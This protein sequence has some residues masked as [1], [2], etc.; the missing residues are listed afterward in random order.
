MES[1]ISDRF[2][3]ERILHKLKET[4][5]AQSGLLGNADL[6]I[7]ISCMQAATS[8]L[9]EVKNI[10]SDLS[11]KSLRNVADNLAST[12]GHFV[13]QRYLIKCYYFMQSNG[14]TTNMLQEGSRPSGVLIFCPLYVAVTEVLTPLLVSETFAGNIASTKISQ[15]FLKDLNVLVLPDSEPE[16]F[17]MLLANIHFLWELSKKPAALVQFRNF[18][19]T[20]LILINVF[21]SYQGPFEQ[22]TT[23]VKSLAV[24]IAAEVADE[25]TSVYLLA[26]ESC[27]D[28]VVEIL[29][30]SVSAGDKYLNY[31]GVYAID[32]AKCILKLSRFEGLQ[33]ALLAKGVVELLVSMI[34]IGDPYDDAAAANALNKLVRNQNIVDVPVLFQGLASYCEK[35]ISATKTE[36]T[37][38]NDDQRIPTSK[39]KEAVESLA[40]GQVGQLAGKDKNDSIVDNKQELTTEEQQ[41]SIEGNIEDKTEK[42]SNVVSD[43]GNE[44]MISE[45][46]ITSEIDPSTVIASRKGKD[47]VT[48]LENNSWNIKEDDKRKEA[49]I[50]EVHLKEDVKEDIGTTIKIMPSHEPNYGERACDQDSQILCHETDNRETT[51]KPEEKNSPRVPST[52]ESETPCTEDRSQLHEAEPRFCQQE[53]IS[54]YMKKQLENMG[55]EEIKYVKM[56]LQLEPDISKQP[57]SEYKQSPAS[58]PFQYQTE[59][60]DPVSGQDLYHIHLSLIDLGVHNMYDQKLVGLLNEILEEAKLREDGVFDILNSVPEVYSYKMLRTGSMQR[61]LRVVPAYNDE[62]LNV[63]FIHVQPEIDYHLVLKKFVF[64]VV[65]DCGSEMDFPGFTL[66]GPWCDAIPTELEE[67]SFCFVSNKTTEGKMQYYLSAERMKQNFLWPILLS[68]V[69]MNFQYKA[70]M[71][72]GESLECENLKCHGITVRK[73]EEN[74]PAVT[75]YYLDKY[76]TVDYVLSLRHTQWPSCAAS[77]PDRQRQWPDSDTVR[78][79][80]NYGC[81]LVP[82]QPACLSESDPLYG[83]FFQ[84]SFARAE[85]VLLNKLNDDNPVL[86]DCLRMLKFLCELHFDR[87]TLLKSYHMQTLVLLAAERLPPSHWKAEHFVKHL[88]DLLDDLLHHLVA[89]N[90]P[91]YFIPQQNLFQQF[92]PDFILDVAVRVSKVRRDPIKYL[93]PSHDPARFGIYL[94]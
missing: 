74:G 40:A 77:W 69:Q 72:K 37:A 16:Q 2:I 11:E 66:I 61:Q 81:H 52:S 94:I 53:E 78:N 31:H 49:E 33:E 44:S 41:Q 7:Q 73:I 70:L 39:E 1:S 58:R 67:W 84:Y 4:L 87:P 19:D 65:K 82:K 46:T 32:I 48:S 54:A 88:L 20:V 43:S 47:K 42:S 5:Q 63:P 55:Q 91:N 6:S 36:V 85:N 68:F 64:Q 12:D 90:L 56:P 27:L 22:L 35:N 86:T 57:G 21:V 26:E 24:M 51:E 60:T 28:F 9:L 13:F 92:A 45:E 18:S 10:L 62:D 75:V 15:L 89:H 71:A 25:E 59:G 30:R 83:M 50:A 8:T 29:T 34:Q 76:L 17:K 93:T 38:S 3:S 14:N 79:I 80:T 23:L